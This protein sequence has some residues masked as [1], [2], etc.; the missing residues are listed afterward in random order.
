ML[1]KTFV[2]SLVLFL[3]LPACQLKTSEE[4]VTTVE[5]PEGVVSLASESAMAQP[6]HA[7]FS[8]RN[9]SFAYEMTYDGELLNLVESQDE[10]V[11][12]FEVEG[13]SVIELRSDW[14]DLVS[15]E[16]EIAGEPVRKGNYDVYQF[17]DAEASCSLDVTLIPYAQE[18]LKVALKICEDNDGDAGRRALEQ[19]LEHL[20][21]NAK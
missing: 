15:K 14:V 9:G 2:L 6:L 1:K 10:S 5:T 3:V 16:A 12:R 8:S 13:G 11:P 17:M 4:E 7:V 20:V 18:Y 19:I 21:L